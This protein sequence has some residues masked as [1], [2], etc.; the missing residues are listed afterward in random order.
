MSK[1]N[2]INDINQKIKGASVANSITPTIL[3]NILIDTVNEIGEGGSGETPTLGDVIGAGN[4]GDEQMILSNLEL[5]SLNISDTPKSESLDSESAVLNQNKLQFNNSKANKDDTISSRVVIGAENIVVRST[6]A[7]ECS[8]VCTNT[9]VNP[10]GV[11]MEKYAPGY[12]VRGRLELP[13]S[14]AGCSL[15]PT[16]VLPAVSGIHT[17]VTSINGN[18]ADEA[19]NVE[20]E[21]GSGSFDG[22]SATVITIETDSLATDDEEGILN[23]LNESGLELPT[24]GTYILEVKDTVYPNKFVY[25]N[26]WDIPNEKQLGMYIE[27]SG[28]PDSALPVPGFKVKGNYLTFDQVDY[29][30][31]GDNQS[32]PNGIYVDKIKEM[33]SSANVASRGFLYNYHNLEKL[34]MP[35]LILAQSSSVTG[36]K[37]KYISMPNLTHAGNGA[38]GSNPSLE[39]VDFPNLEHLDG[40]GLYNC[41]K[42]KK[43]ILPK[44]VGMSGSRI[45]GCVSLEELRLPSLVNNE[46]NYFSMD[47]CTNIKILEAN[48]VNEYW[49]GFWEVAS[50]AIEEIYCNSIPYFRNSNQGIEFPRLRILE[51]NSVTVIRSSSAI[52]NTRLETLSLPSLQKIFNS[53][54]ISSN[55]RLKELNLPALQQIFS[56]TGGI[57]N[58]HELTSLSL[59]SLTGL[60][61]GGTIINNNNLV[62]LSVPELLVTDGSGGIL[63][64]SKLTTVDMPKWDQGL[65]YF[66][67]DGENYTYQSA[68]SYGSNGTF[69]G[70]QMWKVFNAPGTTMLRGHIF[71]DYSNNGYISYFEEVNVANALRI[72]DLTASYLPFLERIVAPLA[73]EIFSSGIEGFLGTSLS[74]PKM[75]TVTGGGIRDCSN[76]TTV[77]MPLAETI[78][79]FTGHPLLTTLT[80]PNVNYIGYMNNLPSLTVLNCPLVTALGSITN[81]AI[82]D[83]NFPNLTEVTGNG[84]QDNTGVTRFYLPLLETFQDT[85]FDGITGRT[86]ALTVP[87]AMSG[88]VP[89][90][91][92]QSNNTVT[93]TLV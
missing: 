2:I 88:S 5:G 45:S 23:Y 16:V 58:N 39:E 11:Q 17:M 41:V 35:N 1:E 18:F 24:D 71:Q 36:N 8:A 87:T 14:Q 72:G 22:L 61:N 28:N 40:S 89:V 7:S 32:F 31:M 70:N 9:T 53:S 65:T 12:T 29:E 30:M 42:L 86:I 90:L 44:L 34:V 60:W 62:T 56:T 81:T 15:Y 25:L 80:I 64:H 4:S 10:D 50:G 63:G 75:K 51:A 57:D 21:G 19:G 27:K 67:T 55:S 26:E 52:K 84:F 83:F 46:G 47:G 38:F 92:L 77:S 33:W 48:N 68:G 49:N 74:F 85:M 43:L 93:L 20:V 59:P 69:A 82:A 66:T 54:F 6:V 79:T 3:G 73:E 91:T 76:L 37:L 13:E 78:S